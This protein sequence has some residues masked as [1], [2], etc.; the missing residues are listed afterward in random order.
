MEHPI[1][2]FAGEERPVDVL[3][4]ID[5]VGGVRTAVEAIAGAAHDSLKELRAGDRVGI[6]VHERESRVILPFTTDMEAVEKAIQTELPALHYGSA[7]RV[8]TAADDA[9]KLFLAEPDLNHRRAVLHVELGVGVVSRLQ[10]LV[11]RK[12]WEAGA[13]YNCVAVHKYAGKV[14]WAFGFGLVGAM[15][16]DAS[17]NAIVRDTGGV[18]VSG[19]DPGEASHD[20]L[21]RIRQRYSLW[22][23]Q[24]NSKYDSVRKLEVKLSDDAA[25]RFPKAKV[26]ARTGYHVTWGAA[27]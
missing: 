2:R 17:N 5:A 15:L 24:P 19:H 10:R 9:A 14:M 4:V 27:K 18:I 22:I 7:S 26:H 6:L 21:R 20:A 13:V 23:E 11:V 1:V 12:Y 16:L 25:K 8:Q 3:V